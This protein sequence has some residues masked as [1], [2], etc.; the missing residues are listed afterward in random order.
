[1][2]TYRINDRI[3]I[4]LT[5]RCSNACEFCVRID[6]KYSD[7]N[8]WLEK[9]PTAEEIIA[10]LGEMEGASEIV[11]C[12]YGE[13]LYRLDAIIPVSEYAHNKGKKT[14]INTNGQARH[15]AGEGVAQK[16]AGYIDT[17]S[18]SLNAGDAKSYQAICHSQFGEQA[19]YDI[20]DF[21]RECKKHIPRVV[22]SIVDVVGEEQIEKARKIAEEVGAELRVRRYI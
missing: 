19:F 20:I 22:F 6:D 18:I 15:I 4:N 17:V 12:G 21:G 9:E 10:E 3:Y 1:M 16:L 13:P 2:I 7:F 11:F 8:L 5:N 14:R